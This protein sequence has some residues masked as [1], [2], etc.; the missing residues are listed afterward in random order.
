MA[1]YWNKNRSGNSKR[2]NVCS[3]VFD[4]VQR[5]SNGNFALENIQALFVQVIAPRCGIL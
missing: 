4:T 1:M 5:L 2:S 3:K